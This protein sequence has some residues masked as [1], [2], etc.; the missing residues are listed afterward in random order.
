MDILS[1]RAI[2][3]QQF[4]AAIDMFDN[5]LR[6]CPDDM[7]RDSLWNDPSVA[8]E[9][10]QLWH[11]SYHALYWLDRYLSCAGSNFTPPAPFIAGALPEKPYTKE[12][13][14]TYL[15]YCR[16]KCQDLLETLTEEKASQSC[17]FPWGEEVS[18]A[19]LQLY[20]MRHIQEH[21]AHISLHIGPRVDHLALDWEAR[22]NH[23]A[24]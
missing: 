17:Q 2:L 23:K 8:P 15:A 21:A 3:W 10:S 19:E 5:A 20:N 18:Y 12:E 11:I 22:A 13:L 6:A 24:A 7:W 1:W 16:Q 4:G 9:Y 14:R